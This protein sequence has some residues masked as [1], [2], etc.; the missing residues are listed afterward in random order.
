MG[1]SV[2]GGGIVAVI[3]SLMVLFPSQ[4]ET[5]RTCPAIFERERKVLC[6][7]EFIASCI[8]TSLHPCY[9]CAMSH[10]IALPC[11]VSV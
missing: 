7:C 2:D 1:E 6:T 9:A 3:R 5:Q 8:Q 10:H 11:T 4:A